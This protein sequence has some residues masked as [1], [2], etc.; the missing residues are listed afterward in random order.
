MIFGV[1]MMLLTSFA[2][3]YFMEQMSIK[4]LS[5]AIILIACFIFY[6]KE[7][8]F[9]ITYGIDI[10]KKYLTRKTA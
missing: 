4:F 1:I 2:N 7:I 5:F 6:R 10:I 9:F 3:Y 8:V